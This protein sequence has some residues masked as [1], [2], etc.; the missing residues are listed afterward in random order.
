[1]TG[2]TKFDFSVIPRRNTFG[3]LE[4]MVSEKMK[5]KQ[6]RSIDEL[7]EERDESQDIEIETDSVRSDVESYD[8]GSRNSDIER[9]NDLL[10]NLFRKKC[11]DIKEKE[12][13][14]EDMKKENSAI[15]KERDRYASLLN[16]KDKVDKMINE[17]LS[18]SDVKKK[19]LEETEKLERLKSETNLA[20]KKLETKETLLNSK[21]MAVEKREI[22]ID[23]EKKLFDERKKF[24][25]RK[26]NSRYSKKE[27]G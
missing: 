11:Q 5:K 12:K 20:I 13:I 10:R 24:R 6:S 26:D 4:E 23:N 8:F 3:S 27:S 2:Q 9:D 19:F 17:N 7:L 14:I 16:E 18:L 15:L 22:F 1:M 21:I 25:W